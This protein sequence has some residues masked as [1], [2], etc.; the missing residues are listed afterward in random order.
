M[1]IGVLLAFGALI[2]WGF[3]DFLIQRSTRAVGIWKTLFSIGVGGTL[4]LTPF[5]F[6]SIGFS[7]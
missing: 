3:G 6:P 7:F 2:G 4:L 1:T 5:V